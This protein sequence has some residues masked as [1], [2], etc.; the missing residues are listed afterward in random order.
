MQNRPI[1]LVRRCPPQAAGLLSALGQA[2]TEREDGPAFA[3]A[4]GAAL[5]ASCP[6]PEDD[7]L[8]SLEK[9]L[10]T[11]LS[12]LDMGLSQVSTEENALLIDIAEYPAVNPT[13][14]HAEVVVFGLFEG[15]LT[16]YLNRLSGE[17][18]LAAR[19][20]APPSR[21]STPLRFVYTNH[22]PQD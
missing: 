3:R 6:D 12:E 8:K 16:T 13:P 11:G 18:K 7:S 10:N 19:L 14:L 5:A 17:N 2:L 15:L 22:S 4:L 20:H 21:T 9:A 1:T